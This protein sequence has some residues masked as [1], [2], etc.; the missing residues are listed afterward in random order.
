MKSFFK[1]LGWVGVLFLCFVSFS[2]GDGVV[3]SIPDSSAN[4]GATNVQVP[5]NIND[6]TN[7]GAF[8]F[9]ISYNP[10]VLKYKN[11]T[12]GTLIQELIS[13]GDWAF[14]KQ[15]TEGKITILAAPLD[16]QNPVVLQG[17]SGSLAIMKFDVIGN[18]GDESP[19]NFNTV[20]DA[21]FVTKLENGKLVKVAVTWKN[22]IFK[23]V[24]APATISGTISYSGTKTGKI[25]IGL[26][27]SSDFSVEPVKGTQINSPGAY[28]ISDV[29][30]GTYYVAAYMDVNNNNTY[31][32]TIDPAGVYA[33]NP[34]TVNAGETKTGIDITLKDPEIPKVATPTFSPA[35]GTYTGSV[36]VTISC[37]TSGA[38]I[39][40]TL[41]GS[42][43][44]ETS[45]QYTGP[46]HLTQTTTIKAKGFK[47][48]MTPSDTATG[49]YTITLAKG[50]VS[51]KITYTG[52][53]TGKIYIGLFTSSNFT[54]QPAYGTTISSP[55]SYQIQDVAPGTYY[56]GAYMDVNN[57]NTY[58]PTIDPAGVYANNPITVNAGETKT[59]IDITLKDPE[60]PIL[61]VSPLSIVF[62]TGETEKVIIV[63]NI[64]KDGLTWSIIGK[65]SWLD[66]SPNSGGPLDA[67]KD[68]KVTLTKTG[69]SPGDSGV[70]KFRNTTEG[71]TQPD[72]EVKVRINTKPE[73]SEIGVFPPKD[74]S[75]I[76]KPETFVHLYAKFK[77]ADN[78]KIVYY[79]WELLTDS[80]KIDT[81]NYES[82]N[83]ISG[84]SINL[85]YALFEKN[86]TYEWRIRC[87]DE[88][89]EYSDGATISFKVNRP[90]STPESSLSEQT[91]SDTIIYTREVDGETIT[92]TTIV[93]SEVPAGVKVYVR[94]IDISKIASGLILGNGE[95]KRAYDIR[96]EG[97]KPGGQIEVKLEVPEN[98]NEIWKYNPKTNK[99]IPLSETY[100]G[101]IKFYPSPKPNVILVGILLQDGREPDDYDGTANGIIVDPTILGS[102]PTQVSG[103]GGCFIATA[104]FGN[105][106]HPFVRILREFRDK[107]LLKNSIGR[108]F[109]NWYYAHSPKYAEIIKN[110]LI[111]KVI[112]QILLIPVVFI[113]YLIVKGLLPLLLLIFCLFILRKKY[114]SKLLILLLL[115]I[116]SKNSFAQDLNLFKI[117]PGEK[118]TVVSP[119]RN[120]LDKGKFQI[121]FVYSFTD[122]LLK[123]VVG[124]NE[125]VIVD[126][127]NLV[128]LG[129]TYGINEKT[130]ISLLIPYLIDQSILPG[131]SLITDDS[132]FGDIY[133]SGKFKVFDGGKECY[134]VLV[135]PF[136]GL[137]NGKN[138]AGIGADEFVY[139]IKFAVDKWLRENL[140]FSV[141]LGYSHQNEVRISQVGIDDTFLF[142]T[143]LTYIFGK[144]YLTTE[145]YGRSDDGFF[146]NREEYPIELN[147]L[148]GHNFNNFDFLIGVGKGITE[149]Y[150]A[151][152]YRIFT[153]IKIGL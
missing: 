29:A 130:N 112:T 82:L 26:F 127:Q 63:K 126:K 149:G 105:Y 152:N 71:S 4:P 3:V 139:G 23:V 20:N 31:D 101:R 85:P 19:L 65:P 77:D 118:Y 11:V 90:E 61:S 115:L 50:T 89:N 96:V 103:G 58:D 57:N 146:D 75:D 22:G 117:A 24:T 42:E 35:P 37:S 147:L 119:T 131:Q 51:G 144:S 47:T 84:M 44:T 53:K 137:S 55:G 69:G 97:L 87:E 17:G 136:I 100:P 102:K 48:G 72:I 9:E 41:D 145:I 13:N 2:Y 54:G 68:Q 125:R 49:T 111:L 43:P 140:L 30:P 123:G 142:G 92:E 98:I 27:T 12:P 59:G 60:I 73:V 33:N 7:V 52:T 32:P 93:S 95:G 15:Q 79:E 28:T 150:S 16:S 67:N 116:L 113:A 62:K 36:D 86:Q 106:N 88:N 74:L 138:E 25:N 99:F 151:P 10:N 18:N 6:C 148:Y 81:G 114:V 14:V 132:G 94:P 70:I 66:V 107:I 121:D 38:T 153:G 5:I 83:G 135:I 141:N 110:N 76:V 80:T 122:D 124:G 133:L 104:C 128:Q 21:S 56:V 40:Y 108:N 1:F 46:I 34:I 120:T 8:V 91:N 134:G 45:T 39:R 143:S 109:V 129:L 64:G 78:D